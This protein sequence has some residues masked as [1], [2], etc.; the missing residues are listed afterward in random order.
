VSLYFLIGFR[1]RFAAALNR[2]W[3]YITFSEAA[4]SSLNCTRDG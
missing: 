4:A 1:N 3:S 2:G